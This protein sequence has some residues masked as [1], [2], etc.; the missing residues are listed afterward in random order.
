MVVQNIQEKLHFFFEVDCSKGLRYALSRQHDRVFSPT[1]PV[2]HEAQS[3]RGWV[4]F[5]SELLS[6]RLGSQARSD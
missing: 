1:G 2:I 3:G 4:R 6:S 5:E